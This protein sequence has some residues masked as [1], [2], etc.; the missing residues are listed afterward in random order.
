[1]S[2]IA[3][4]V[5]ELARPI[6]DELGLELFDVEYVKE[7]GSMVLRLYID[8]EAGI[9]HAECEAMSRRLDEVLDQKDLIAGAYNLE[10]SSPGAERPL[11][12]ERDFTRFAGKQVLVKTYAPV[13]G[14]K[15][16]KGELIG[17]QDGE[18]RIKGP[19]G[20]M[21]FPKDQVSLVR[22]TID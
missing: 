10:V 11:R 14:N 21:A 4:Q 8:S 7:G 19:K 12:S 3:E 20:D 17:Q 1:M 5:T 22:L 15:E 6:A 16:W 9:S 18:I 13:D 2:R